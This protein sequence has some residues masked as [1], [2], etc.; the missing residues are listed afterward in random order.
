[1]EGINSHLDFSRFKK[2]GPTSE[3]AELIGRIEA[4]TNP[5]RIK[6]GYRP[7]TYSRIGD[8]VAH[9]NLTDLRDHVVQAEKAANRSQYFWGKLR[10]KD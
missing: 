8:L 3:R 5:S 2:S 10:V 4:F 1:M 9:L 7:Y 6:A